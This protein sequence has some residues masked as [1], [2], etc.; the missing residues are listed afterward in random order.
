MERMCQNIRDYHNKEITLKVLK[1]RQRENIWKFYLYK[2]KTLTLYI[3]K[4]ATKRNTY[5]S[6]ALTSSHTSLNK[7]RSPIKQADLNTLETLI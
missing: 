3:G 5:T 1:S 4:S 6:Y 7:T 2:Q